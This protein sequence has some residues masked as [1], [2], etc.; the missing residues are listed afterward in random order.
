MNNLE[1]LSHNQETGVGF[2]AIKE[3]MRTMLNGGKLE[4][5]TQ[6][7]EAAIDGG[8]DTMLQTI[9]WLR[10]NYLTLFLRLSP[11]LLAACATI[12]DPQ[13]VS[14]ADIQKS[15]DQQRAGAATLELNSDQVADLQATPVAT[16]IPTR[17]PVTPTRIP[18][19]PGSAN[20]SRGADAVEVTA[21]PTPVKV[22]APTAEPTPTPI[23]LEPRDVTVIAITKAGINVREDHST[24]AKIAFTTEDNGISLEAT[25]KEFDDGNYIWYQMKHPDFGIVADAPEFIW[26][27]G[28]PGVDKK[29]VTVQGGTG[30]LVEDSN[31]T[32]V[33]DADL[34]EASAALNAEV[35]SIETQA[36]VK[37]ALDAKGII[38]GTKVG[39]GPWTPT[40]FPTPTPE[41]VVELENAT[42]ETV[43][44][45]IEP[46]ELAGSRPIGLGEG[47][48]P[49][50]ASLLVNEAYV[51]LILQHNPNLT[52]SELA[53][54]I[55]QDGTVQIKVIAEEPKERT[56]RAPSIVGKP[57]VITIRPKLGIS[58]QRFADQGDLLTNIMNSGI[59]VEGQ[60]A[61]TGEIPPESLRLTF[62]GEIVGAFIVVSSTDARV[63]TYADQN[64]QLV[65]GVAKIGKNSNT[66]YLW[67]ALIRNTYPEAY[68]DHAT[69]GGAFSENLR[70]AGLG[71][72]YNESPSAINRVGTQ[73]VQLPSYLQRENWLKTNPEKT[74]YTW[75]LLDQSQP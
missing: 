25:G 30:G 46:F 14:A 22:L 70:D 61:I 1:S 5:V 75:A 7:V 57:Q 15:L 63:Y 43:A 3:R 60:L 59:T 26:V 40:F 38:L 8:V 2:S 44:R 37:K 23:E 45:M 42:I 62:N 36:T 72:N 55:Q 53:K 20:L 51:G 32:I 31:E 33:T 50:Q 29:T 52:L 10:E 4:E 18:A 73:D 35:T 24:T 64:G 12:T 74:T 66:A 39:N 6:K 71:K 11:L 54:I 41:N 21:S 13:P 67:G 17:K 16:A 65:I 34:Q 19:L 48:T 9:T 56:G 69:G 28:L 47:V 49:E 58:Y 27:A 68:M